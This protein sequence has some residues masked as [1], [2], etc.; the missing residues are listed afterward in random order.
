MSD[1]CEPAKLAASDAD[2]TGSF[3]RRV[4]RGDPSADGPLQRRVQ[5]GD[6]I[7]DGEPFGPTAVD[8]LPRG[9][10][11]FPGEFLHL[12]SLLGHVPILAESTARVSTE[13]APPVQVAF[14]A[15]MKTPSCPEHAVVSRNYPAHHPSRHECSELL[16]V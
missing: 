11:K 14:S 13:L 2:T 9:D 5:F 7:L 3:G 1:V 8:E 10:P 12:D 16:T 4:A 15:R 6:A